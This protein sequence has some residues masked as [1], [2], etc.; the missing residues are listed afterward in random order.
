[1][2]EYSTE[3]E[4]RARTGR[5]PVGLKWIDTNKRSAEA[6]RYSSRLVCTEVR[7]KGVEPIFSATPPLETLRILLSVACQEDVFRV[8]DPFLISIADVSRA[9]FHADAVRDVY[10]RLPEEE[11]KAKQA[12]VCGKLRGD[13][14]RI[15]G[16]SPTMER[17][18]RSSFGDWRIFPEAWHLRVISSTRTWRL[19]FWCTVMIFHWPT[20]GAKACTEFAARCIRAEQSGDSGP[21]IVAVTDSEFPG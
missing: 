10:V 2:Y 12:G 9:H 7:H 1:M 11:P 13:D 15:F 4:A 16:R 8:E 6:P 3:A 17:A 19:A 21:R 18:L 14:V 20:R 5:N